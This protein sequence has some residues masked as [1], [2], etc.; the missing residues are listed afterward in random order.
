L[1]AFH[2]QLHSK[3]YAKYIDGECVVIYQTALYVNQPLFG[4]VCSYLSKQDLMFHKFLGLAGRTLS[5]ITIDNNP[6]LATQHC[7]SDAVFI[8]DIFKVSDLT[9]VQ[10]LKLS[11]LAFLYGSPDLTFH[12]LQH[13]DKLMG[14]KSSASFL[15]L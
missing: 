2:C 4:D 14:T 11:M 8:R 13:F 12:A 15:N 10:L 9:S 3:K 7:W 5:P 1:V 6:N